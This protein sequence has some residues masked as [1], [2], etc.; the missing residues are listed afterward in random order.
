MLSLLVLK[1]L[2]SCPGISVMGDYSPYLAFLCHVAV[3][4]GKLPSFL[5]QCHLLEEASRTTVPSKPHTEGPASASINWLPEWTRQVWQT[6]PICHRHLQCLTG[7]F[8]QVHMRAGLVKSL[9]LADYYTE[10]LRAVVWSCH[11]EKWGTSSEHQGGDT[12]R[13]NTHRMSPKI[14]VTLGKQD[15]NK[16]HHWSIK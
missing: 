3:S 15:S 12:C 1:W 13:L 9:S 10:W 14:R 7:T 16:F 2:A 5:I 6:T 11:T 4:G 8:L